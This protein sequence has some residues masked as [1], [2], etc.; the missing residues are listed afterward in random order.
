[1]ENVIISIKPVFC[2]AIY[3]GN[4]A[5]EL[6]KSVGTG[7]VSGAKLY[8][9][10]SSPEK[11][12]TGEAVIERIQR[13]EVSV[14]K[15]K[16]LVSACISERDFDRYYLGKEYG[17]VISLIDVRKYNITASLGELRKLG[18]HAPQSYSYPS[19]EILRYI[20]ARRCI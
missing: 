16:Y 5:V 1:M 12:I 10:T 2:K 20:E 11:A 19:Q 17:H 7:F 9:Y 6:R 3:S 15:E 8:I 14:I 18:F 4:K 13:L